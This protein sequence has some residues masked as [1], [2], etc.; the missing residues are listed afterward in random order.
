MTQTTTINVDISKPNV[1]IA[2][3]A[4]QHDIDTRKVEVSLY[5]NG[6][7]YIVPSGVS[8][9]VNVGKPDGTGCYYDVDSINGNKVTFTLVEQALAAYGEAKVDVSLLS[10]ED[11]EITERLTSFSFRL[12]IEKRAVEDSLIVSSDYYNALVDLSGTVLRSVTFTPSVNSNG[13]LSWTN[14]GGITNP[15]T[16]NIRGPQGIQGPQGMQGVPG[17]G[18]Y[19]TAGSHNSIYRGEYLGNAVTN[20]QWSAI[21]NGTFED[22]Y[23]GDYWTIDNVNWRIA[24]FDYWLHFG[25]IECKTHHVV[26]VPDTNLVAGILMNST[27][28]TTGA[29]T[30]SDFYTGA[31]GNTGKSQCVT[32]INAAFGSAHILSHREYLKNT[33]TNGYESNGTWYNST[34]ELMTEQMVYGCKVFGN[35]V[36]GTNIP[37]SFTIDNAQLPLF[38]HDH[39]KICNRAIWWL[40]DVVSATSFAIVNSGGRSDYYSASDSA[41]G[42]RPVFAIGA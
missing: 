38:A 15:E 8:G 24:A 13:D 5:D 40:R 12:I 7:E 30:G 20:A 32:Q 39:S 16:V 21:G 23:I 1:P 28:V 17:P 33:V 27:N 6:S 10:I 2:V 34:I 18:A 9:Q 11:D 36:S 31:N 26:I 41:V 22:L 14:N 19:S 37:A 35:V 4:K 3:Y 42:I 29:Y 25:D